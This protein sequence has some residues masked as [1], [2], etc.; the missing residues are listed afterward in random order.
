MR[1]SDLRKITHKNVEGDHL[2]W[3]PEKTRETSGKAVRMLIT[4]V[5]Q[6]LMTEEKGK[7]MPAIS[8]QKYNEYLK[9]VARLAGIDKVLTSHV[10]RHTYATTFL[11]HG[12]SIEVLQNLMGLSSLKT[13]MVYVHITEKRKDQE[14][15]AAWSWC[16][17]KKGAP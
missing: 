2:V 12:G 9:E 17:K 6:E 1:Y 16:E 13:L 7:L 3:V 8:N 5:M 4:P 15:A 14:Q 10:G 11:H